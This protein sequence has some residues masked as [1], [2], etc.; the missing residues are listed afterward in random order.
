MLQ[1]WRANSDTGNYIFND[2]TKTTDD[3]IEKCRQ[4]WD[5]RLV[6]FNL[7]E[8]R[9]WG[10]ASTVSVRFSRDPA[11]V[12]LADSAKVFVKKTGTMYAGNNIMVGN[13]RAAD[14]TWDDVICMTLCHIH[15]RCNVIDYNTVIGWCRLKEK[16]ALN[17]KMDSAHISY[18]S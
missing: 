2:V 5:C 15:P 7:N 4:A 9:C 6:T 3:C 10:M 14:D 8:K 11:H 13:Q 18:I 1:G 12:L 17:P 16:Y